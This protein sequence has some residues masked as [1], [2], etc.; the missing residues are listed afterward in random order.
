MLFFSHIL[1]YPRKKNLPYGILLTMMFIA[2]RV[3]MFA[4]MTILRYFENGV[5]F[6]EYCI[7][8]IW[9]IISYIRIFPVVR[10]KILR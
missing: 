3:M 1:A 10:Y 8:I 4:K 6:L 9:T 5:Q 7:I 2:F